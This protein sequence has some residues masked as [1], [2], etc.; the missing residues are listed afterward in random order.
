MYDCLIYE[1]IV[2]LEI[3]GK[4]IYL[5]YYYCVIHFTYSIVIFNKI[6]TYY[7]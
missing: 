2:F 3:F 4:Q 7:S 5:L 1:H 6:I